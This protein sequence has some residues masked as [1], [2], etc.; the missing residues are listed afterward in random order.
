MMAGEGARVWLW[1][2]VGW[3]AWWALEQGFFRV[4]NEA[5]KGTKG[6]RGDG[7]TKTVS[8]RD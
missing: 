6:A 1:Q 8:V 4:A 3:L 2:V 7:E 5:T